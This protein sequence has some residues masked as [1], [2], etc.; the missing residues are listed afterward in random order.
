M[1]AGTGVLVLY[2]PFCCCRW[3]VRLSRSVNRNASLNLGVRQ[4]L[5]MFNGSLLTEYWQDVTSS[6]VTRVS[7]SLSVLTAI[8]PGGPG[9][10]GTTVFPFW[11]LLE[12]RMMEVVVTITGAVKCVKLQSNHH[13]QQTNTHFFTG[14]MP[15]LSPKCPSRGGKMSHSV[16]LITPSWRGCLVR[17]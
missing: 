13:H 1:C 15:F 3:N 6:R 11:I 10:A 14:R 17:L 8:F 4:E 9:L 2:S 12:L 5:L 16:D 7:L